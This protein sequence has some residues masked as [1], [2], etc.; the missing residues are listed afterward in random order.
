MARDLI[1][2][3]GEHSSPKEVVMAVQEELEK[4]AENAEDADMYPDE[5]ENSW[6]ERLI[7]L[8]RLCCAGM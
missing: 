1:T 4:I 5:K 8:L 2:Q 7:E 3:M 6:V